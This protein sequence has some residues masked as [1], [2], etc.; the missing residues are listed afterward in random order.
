MRVWAILA[1]LLALSYGIALAEEE[2]SFDFSEI[3][4]RALD[5]GGYLEFRPFLLGL[6]NNAAL[7]KL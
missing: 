4:E 7:H 5:L 2:Y 1:I 6:D 3:E